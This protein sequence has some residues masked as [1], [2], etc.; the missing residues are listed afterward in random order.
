MTNNPHTTIATQRAGLETCDRA[1]REPARTLNSYANIRAS[2]AT[3][4][5]APGRTGHRKP[6]QRSPLYSRRR[7]VQSNHQ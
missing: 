4:V 2:P 7:V 1:L 5:K 6:R 3:T